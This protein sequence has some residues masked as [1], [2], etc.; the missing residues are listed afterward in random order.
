MPNNQGIIA[1]VPMD[2]LFSAPK[3]HGRLLAVPI[4][5]EDIESFHKCAKTVS[6]LQREIERVGSITM[7]LS[8]DFTLVPQEVNLASIWPQEVCDAFARWILGFDA[9]KDAR[10]RYPNFTFFPLGHSSDDV[11]KSL[12][13]KKKT[14]SYVLPGVARIYPF[15]MVYKGPDF[16]TRSINSRDLMA[17]SCYFEP[18]DR[19]REIFPEL[20]KDHPAA[21]LFLLEHGLSPVGVPREKRRTL[22]AMPSSAF[23]PL[24]QHPAREIRERAIAALN[25]VT[26]VHRPT[27]WTNSVRSPKITV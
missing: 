20:A 23:A 25:R 8:A 13:A 4:V 19:V 15:H 26:L 3:Y 24:L 11:I 12:F 9:R 10:N 1:L 6:Q 14:H 5:R 16:E 22:P 27:T 17:M 2:G 7:G 21:A 18:D